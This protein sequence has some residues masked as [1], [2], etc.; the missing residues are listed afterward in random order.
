MLRRELIG[1]SVISFWVFLVDKRLIFFF[2]NNDSKYSNRLYILSCEGIVR[3]PKFSPEIF[4]EK[5]TRLLSV[6]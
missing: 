4:K 3:V 6:P 5:G 1:T 2:K